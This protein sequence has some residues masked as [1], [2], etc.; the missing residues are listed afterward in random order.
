M[1]CLPVT[2]WPQFVGFLELDQVHLVKSNFKI[3]PDVRM[4]CFFNGFCEL[5]LTERLDVFHEAVGGRKK[6]IQV[7]ELEIFF[8]VSVKDVPGVLLIQIHS[9]D[10]M[11]PENK[12]FKVKKSGRERDC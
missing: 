4:I 3:L 11:R 9:V 10:L 8:E 2:R 1:R 6:D 5:R 7:Y 12:N